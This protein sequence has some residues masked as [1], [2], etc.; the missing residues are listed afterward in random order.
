M[1]LLGERLRISLETVPLYA[2]LGLSA[3]V[4]PMNGSRWPVFAF[5]IVLFI[6]LYF[7]GRI[8]RVAQDVI[9]PFRMGLL[10]TVILLSIGT[11]GTVATSALQERIVE[12]DDSERRI[13]E[14]IQEPFELV[15][16]A[17]F[18]GY[19]VGSTYQAASVLVSSSVGTWGPSGYYEEAPERLMLELGVIGFLLQYLLYAGILLYAYRII[20]RANEPRRLFLAIASFSFVL[21]HLTEHVAFNAVASAFFWGFVGILVALGE[22]SRTYRILVAQ[23]IPQS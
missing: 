14:R 20:H 7:S 1:L 13:I 6:L 15:E 10:V 4:V 11:Y 3:I 23:R 12:A 21:V 18:Y 22:E 5:A 9:S 2:A 19:G 8:Q 16:K 17:G